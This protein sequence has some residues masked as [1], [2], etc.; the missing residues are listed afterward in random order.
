MSQI[1]FTADELNK[2]LK[3]LIDNHIAQIEDVPETRLK[4]TATV[5]LKEIIADLMA[6]NNQRIARDIEVLFKR[7]G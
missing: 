6:A 2:L 3:E 5:A 1:G 7:L 4:R